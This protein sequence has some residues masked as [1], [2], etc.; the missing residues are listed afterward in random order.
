MGKSNP[1]IRKGTAENE[2]GLSLE[3]QK[4]P[5][6]LSTEDLKIKVSDPFKLGREILKLE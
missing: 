5:L 4:T 1:N 3:L 2:R 6:K